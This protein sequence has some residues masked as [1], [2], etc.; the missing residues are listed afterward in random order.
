[1]HNFHRI[2]IFLTANPD[3]TSLGRSAV[4]ITKKINHIME[5]KYE[6][7]KIQSSALKVNTKRQN[8]TI[9]AAYCPLGEM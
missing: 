1:M 3:N 6:S 9:V 5:N 8:V 7:D 4:I 2:H